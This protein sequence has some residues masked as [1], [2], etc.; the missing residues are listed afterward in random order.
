MYQRPITGAYDWGASEDANFKI[1]DL[2]HAAVNGRG[3]FDAQNPAEL[4]SALEQAFS[5]F[6]SGIGAGSAVS[7]NSQEITNGVVLFRSFT[8]S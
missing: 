7:F 3:L 5:E 8:T 2:H 1:K 6:S 4:T